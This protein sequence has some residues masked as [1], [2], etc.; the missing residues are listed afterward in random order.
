[1][2]RWDDD[3]LDGTIFH[4]LAHQLVY[5]KGDTAFNESFATF[6]Q[7]EGLREWR[8]SRGLPPPDSHAQAMADGFTRLVLDLRE[9]L[10][11]MYASGV[12]VSTMAAGTTGAH[13]QV[14]HRYTQL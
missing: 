14:R 10:N 1:M 4:E 8:Q 7:T 12:D 13:W 11:A 9:R 6:V 3:E 5:V 2:L